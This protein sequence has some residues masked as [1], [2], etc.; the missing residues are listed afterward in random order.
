MS[1]SEYDT[2]QYD[3]TRSI[4]VKRVLL[5]VAV[6]APCVVVLT[7]VPLGSEPARSSFFASKLS[8]AELFRELKKAEPL[9]FEP[10]GRTSVSFRVRLEGNT[11]AAYKVATRYFPRAPFAEVAAYRVASLL[12]LDNVPPAVLRRIAREQITALM[13]R[14]HKHRW[15][16]L[17]PEVLWVD[18]GFAE[19][20]ASLWVLG[21]RS[22]SLEERQK[23]WRQ[24]LRGSTVIPSKH[25][26][27]ARDLSN[28]VVFD[29]LVG[30]RDRFA[31]G[32]MLVLP[33]AGR[34]VLIDQDHAFPVEPGA[35][36]KSTFLLESL[37]LTERF[38]R[39]TVERLRA[40]DEGDL[41]GALG[42]PPRALL[43]P[44]Q[45]EAIMVRR[46]VVLAHLAKLAQERG[47]GAVLYFD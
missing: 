19:G 6:L 17:Q 47:E 39:A 34:L 5:S 30:N 32:Q 36:V 25:V 3:R 31:R 35:G 8:D 11:T 2:S 24:W 27:L 41:R 13:G 12:G 18:D 10:V 15:Q 16:E 45:I 33:S 43:P 23:W 9:H 42:A 4:F 14:R 1:A 21:L 26:A 20:V 7:P 22:W 44:D 29:Y 37:R 28:M 38:S 40:L 46:R